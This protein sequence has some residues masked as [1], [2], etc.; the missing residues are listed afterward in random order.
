MVVTSPS[1][2]VS[3]PAEFCPA[4]PAVLAGSDS[5]VEEHPA[6][7]PA[8]MAAKHIVAKVLLITLPPKYL[9]WIIRQQFFCLLLINIYK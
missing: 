4:S 5:S 7:V 2:V 8:S 6:N 3:D 9:F 1:A